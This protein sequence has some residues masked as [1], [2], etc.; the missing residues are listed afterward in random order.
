MKNKFIRYLLF[1]GF[2]LAIGLNS[3]SEDNDS[4]DQS[5]IETI[6]ENVSI[7]KSN[8]SETGT[9]ELKFDMLNEI[10]LK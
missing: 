7:Q 9:I 3:C 4:T 10:V 5:N 2:L 1:L 6:I 8:S